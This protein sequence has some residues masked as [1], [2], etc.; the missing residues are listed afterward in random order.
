M[1]GGGGGGGKSRGNVGE[2][3]KEGG[4]MVAAKNIV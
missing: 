3:G 1:K 4:E 2:L